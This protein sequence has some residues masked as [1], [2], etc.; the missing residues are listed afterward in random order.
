VTNLIDVDRDEHATSFCGLEFDGLSAWRQI[1]D[2]L[3][4]TLGE[5]AVLSGALDSEDPDDEAQ[6]IL[7]DALLGEIDVARAWIVS[8][9]DW[10]THP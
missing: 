8:R 9:I 6:L 3:A 4:E 7:L 5:A 2:M 10:L 1:P